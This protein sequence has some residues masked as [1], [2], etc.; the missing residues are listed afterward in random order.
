MIYTYKSS[1]VLLL[2][3]F[4]VTISTPNIDK[5]VSMLFAQRWWT[6]VDS[7]KVP[8][9]PNI[10]IETTLNRSNSFNVVST[11]LCERSNNVDKDTSAQLSFSTKFQCWNNFGSPTLNQRHSINVV[12]TLFCQRWN[13]VDKSTSAQLLFSFC[14][15]VDS[16]LMY[17]LGTSW[18]PNY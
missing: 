18:S 5:F 6:Y 13:N 15:N 14:F 10:D 9:Q 4:L 16:T 7:V 8:F 17:W 1:F 2:S 11:L 3:H 12:S